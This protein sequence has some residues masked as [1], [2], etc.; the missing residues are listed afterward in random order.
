MEKAVKNKGKAGESTHK[1][2]EEAEQ[3]SSTGELGME[4]Q[5]P[6]SLPSDWNLTLLSTNKIF[7]GSRLI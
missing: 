6:E 3:C 4:P 1:N 7:V 2:G 5:V